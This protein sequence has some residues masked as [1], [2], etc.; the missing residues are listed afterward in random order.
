MRVFIIGGTGF[1]S[2]ALVRRLLEAGHEVTTFTRGRAS[3]PVAADH[4]RLLTRTG[5][6]H[7]R[8]SLEA[9][10]DGEPF[11]AVYDMIAYSP[12]ESKMAIDVFRGR[13]ERFIHCST[14]SVYMVSNDVD[15]PITEDQDKRRVM[16]YWPRNPF[17]M[18]YGINKRKCEDVL[19]EAHRKGWHDVSM[20]RPPYVA[21]PEDPTIRDYF[22]IERILDG[23]PLLV[24]GE[25]EDE[26]QLVYVEDVGRAFASLLDHPESSGKAYNVADE[27]IVTLNGY[28]QRVA[29]LLDRERDLELVHVPQD[30]FDKL[31]FS[32]YP[33]ADVFPYNTRR[34]ATFSLER[35]KEDLG[36]GS[37]PFDEWMRAT[38]DWYREQTGLR[39]HGYE[40]RRDELSYIASL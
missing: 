31:S 9:A 34:C 38:V 14:I 19:W 22:W 3:P 33:G 23:G 10:A 28:L 32:T 35:I 20:L 6:R 13:T 7:H 27:E 24:P 18:D 15:C 40:Y 21:G 11:D 36:Y 37:T 12:D 5:D 25:G 30:E 2:G 1:I 4:P 29:K 16:D 39:S 8:S 17:G 26:F